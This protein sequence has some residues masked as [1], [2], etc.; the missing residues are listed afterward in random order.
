MNTLKLFIVF[1]VLILSKECCVAKKSKDDGELIFA[2]VIFRHG[3]RTPIDPYP[4]DPWGY[5]K[6]WPTGWGQLTNTG[7][8]QHYELGKYLRKRYQNLI[9]DHYDREEVYVRSTDVDRTLMSAMSNLAGLY[10]PVEDQ[11]WNPDLLWQP[12]PVH[13]IPEKMDYV[14][15]AKKFCPAYSAE[16]DRV[17]SSPEYR[18]INAKNAELYK[19][20]TA[21][22]GR[23]ISNIEGVE[24]IYN[25]LFIEDLYNKTLP[26]W[27]MDVYPDKM[28][29]ISILSFKTYTRTDLLKRLKTGPLLKEI[30]L[31]FKDKIRGKL[32]PNRSLWIYS[33]HDTTVANILNTLGAFY[34]HNPP[35]TACVMLELRK[36]A[37]EYFVE[38]Y[39]RVDG[40]TNQLKLNLCGDV[41][42]LDKAFRSYAHLMPLDWDR[43][44]STSTRLLSLVGVEG[45]NA[46]LF[47]AIG[48]VAGA[49]VVV[50]IL[51]TILLLLSRWR[52]SSQRRHRY[53]RIES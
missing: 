32:T 52:V 43:E 28:I 7:K 11:V 49:V 18:K 22:T 30:L 23:L 48:V 31:R 19:Y 4:T 14:L 34:P 17:L 51:A 21:Q 42:P 27:T 36:R 50:T 12:I 46:N 9:S 53:T 33:A 35:Y 15:A 25:C 47:A 3:D 1:L 24:R 39:Y 20:L 45:D 44:C 40:V 29:N 37:D 38:L 26:D 6:F 13:T 41:C 16:L 10:P 5:R 8:K 2:H